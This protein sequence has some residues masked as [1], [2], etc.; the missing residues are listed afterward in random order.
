MPEPFS[1]TGAG[2]SREQPA[3]AA[4]PRGGVGGG[5]LGSGIAAPLAAHNATAGAHSVDGGVPGARG[6]GGGSGHP[7]AVHGSG[8]AGHHAATTLSGPGH[9][10]AAGSDGR[11]LPSYGVDPERWAEAERLTQAQ[12]IDHVLGALCELDLVGVDTHLERFVTTT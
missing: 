8:T 5:E 9:P 4:R 6:A 3:S 11:A 1:Q 2:D 10:E 7:R 12:W